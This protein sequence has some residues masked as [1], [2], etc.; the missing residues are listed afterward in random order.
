MK[1]MTDTERLRALAAM[2]VD[3]EH[4]NETLTTWEDVRRAAQQIL[5]EAK[6]V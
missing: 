4:S 1:A 5:N 2:I 3:S 6:E